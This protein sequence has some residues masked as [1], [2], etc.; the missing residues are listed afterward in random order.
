[1]ARQSVPGKLQLVYSEE[2]I[3]TRIAELSADI[4]GWADV[5]M[6]KTKVQPLAVCVL[7]GAVLFFS[8]LL[9]AVPV[10]IE[11]TFCR[12]SSYSVE[13][14]EQG[15]EGVRV[16]VEEVEAEGRAILMVDDICDTGATLFTLE[17]VFYEL[18]AT[19][20]QSA[21]LIHRQIPHSKYRPTW[22]AFEYTGD[23][24]FVGYGLDDQNWHRN[25]PDVYRMSKPA[26]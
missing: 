19:E 4:G 15:R 14:N 25:L 22:S 21:V 3:Q 23:E 7:R 9:R 24:W 5:V 2:Q 16:S 13:T 1:M 12:A 17:K 18:G 26:A 10:S 20:V 11:P 6:A 8:D